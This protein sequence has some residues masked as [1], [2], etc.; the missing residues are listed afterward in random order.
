ML[1][2][3]REEFKTMFGKKP[4]E[5]FDLTKILTPKHRIEAMQQPNPNLMRVRRE[6]GTI[7]SGDPKLKPIIYAIDVGYFVDKDGFKAVI[8]HVI[9]FDDQAEQDLAKAKASAHADTQRWNDN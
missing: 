3:T 2:L 9:I 5:L 6:F 7:V 1:E 4:G 8:E